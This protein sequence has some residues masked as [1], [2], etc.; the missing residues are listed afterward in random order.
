MIKYIDTLDNPEV[1]VFATLT[2]AQL[3]NRLDPDKGIFIAESPKVIRVA[4]DAGLEPLALLCEERHIEGDAADIIARC[5]AMTVIP[6]LAS[7]LRRSQA[8]HLPVECFAPCVVPWRLRSTKWC[9]THG[10]WL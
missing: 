8:I 5:P 9:A 1:A 3:R 4:L 2:E 10:V 6:V 7:C